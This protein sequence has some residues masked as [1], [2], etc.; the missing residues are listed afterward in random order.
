MLSLLVVVPTPM[1]CCFLP[2]ISTC[3]AAELMYVDAMAEANPL[4]RITDRLHDP[5]VGWRLR[6]SAG[7]Y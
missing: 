6:V 1:P 5:Q 3:K 4:L 7:V 2:T